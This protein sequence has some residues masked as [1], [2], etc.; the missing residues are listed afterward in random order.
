MLR[1]ALTVSLLTVGNYWLYTM[2]AASADELEQYERYL[3]AEPEEMQWWLDAR[4]GMFIHWAPVSMVGTEIGWSRKGE[5]GGVPDDGIIPTL[6]YDNLYLGFDPYKF[7]AKAWVAL[8]KAAGQKYLVITAKHHDG[9]CMW[10][11]QTTNL[12]IMHS[13]F[14]R[15]IVAEL[16]D[17]C[18]EAGMR[19]GIYYSIQDWHHPDHRTENHA[20]YNQYMMGQLRELLTKY[21]KVDVVWFDSVQAVPGPEYYNM[22]EQF[23]QIRTLQPGIIINGRGA[24][25]R[26]DYDTLEG[27]SGSFRH[28][29]PWETALKMMF[30]WSWSGDSPVKSL[31]DCLRIMLQNA[32]NSGNLL[33]N[34][35]PMPNGQIAPEQVRRLHEIGE[36]MKRNGESIYGTR[37]GPFKPSPQ[38]M[39]THKGNRIYLHLLDPQLSFPLKLN[40]LEKKVLAASI[41]G[42]NSVKVKQT[43][44]S[45]QIE[46]QQALPDQLD[47]VIVLELDGPAAELTPR[48]AKRSGSVAF[49]R[50][51]KASAT[52]PIPFPGTSSPCSDPG[53]AVDD[54]FTTAWRGDDSQLPV[55][56]EVDLGEVQTIDRI[57][58]SSN[59]NDHFFTR[60]FQLQYKQDGTWHTIDG[61]PTGLEWKVPFNPP[62]VIGYRHEV[63]FAAIATSEVRLRI[64][65]CEGG[66]APGIR[67]FQVYPVAKSAG[68]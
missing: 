57:L 1:I 23:K 41:L 36:W 55:T 21:G 7:D 64:T 30:L 25:L 48:V 47:T 43:A 61:K 18:H 13:P 39:S 26:G 68:R 63:T 24:G 3:Y 10:D 5:R 22:H 8:A 56:L 53:F 31:K 62:T 28:P 17:A 16:A 9:F 20:Q 54:D 51:I 45:L 6:V 11:T 40:L 50:P 49:G 44:D 58:L 59:D 66:G 12:N 35:S 46:M 32:S 65:A 4:F 29:R 67:E 37:G 52:N 42:G 14:G 38:I 15:D 19:F 27:G 60:T 34:V 2:G 33:L